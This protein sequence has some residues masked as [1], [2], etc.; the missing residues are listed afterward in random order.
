MRPLGLCRKFS[1]SV[2]RRLA[3]GN[4]FETGTGRSPVASER[5]AFTVKKSCGLALLL[6]VALVATYAGITWSR[7]HDQVMAIGVGVLGGTFASIL[8]GSA[9]GLIQGIRDRAAIKRAQKSAPR[10]DGRLESASG[11]IHA[12]ETVLEG[13]FTGSRYVAYEYNVKNM[14]AER[15]DFA[16]FAL[17]P[18]AIETSTGPVKILGW[19]PLDNFVNREKEIDRERGTSYLESTSSEPLGMMNALSMVS[20]LLA[21][22]DGTIRKDYRIADSLVDLESRRIVEK[23]IEEGATVTA[24]G[25]W[26]ASKGGFVPSGSGIRLFPYG[27]T[28]TAGEVAGKSRK[29]FLV[30][31]AFFVV[32]HAML[33]PFYLKT[34]GGTKL[35][36]AAGGKRHS[37]ASVWDERDCGRL[38]QLLD[39]GANPNEQSPGGR[40]PLM[41]AVSN[42]EIDCIKHLLAAG[43]LPD[44]K[45]EDGSSAMT[46]AITS[47]RENLVTLFKEAGGTDFRVTEANGA[48]LGPEEQPVLT[49]KAYLEAI[50]EGDLEALGRLRDP[51]TATFVTKHDV[52]KLWQQTR[53]A[54]ALFVSGFWNDAAATLTVRGATASSKGTEIEF[55]YHLEKRTD[56]WHVAYEWF[57]D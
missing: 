50:Q 47:E 48:P 21:D 17:T 40:T 9:Y 35:T 56:G 55:H 29:M 20:T 8:I 14:Q 1:K 15:S 24:L 51:A 7:F 43:A 16:G 25:V 10:S 3:I 44:T 45:D 31:F 13:P 57:K 27:P 19:A 33:L 23:G 34:T 18:C 6:W 12:L 39:E 30:G 11:P 28:L 41:N 4:G 2:F 42:S 36:G 54:Q 38:K 26:S 22:D 37:N 5:I 46:W 52:L 32:F 53:P 49:V